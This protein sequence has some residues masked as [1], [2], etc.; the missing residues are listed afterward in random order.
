MILSIIIITFI[1]SVY[2]FNENNIMAKLQF[3]AYRIVHHNEWYRVFS[4]ALLH[5]SW[6]H[7]IIN[8]LVLYSFGEFVLSVFKHEFVFMNHN[9]L[10]ILYYV[11]AV[12]IASIYSLAKHRNNVYYNAVGASGA[13]SAVVFTAIFFEP[14]QKILFFG[15]LPIP[16]IIFGLLY[17]GYSYYMSK[18]ELD[19]VGHDA[20][21]YGALFGFLFPIMLK[22][23][24]LIFFINRI[25]QLQ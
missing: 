8:M 12:A 4:H 22:P 25:I 18:K 16:G 14:Y 3:N 17:L 7:L 2:A 24:L 21:F 15:V 9:L 23:S 19:N 11:F 5:G 6:M 10:F 20:H 1:V 13:I